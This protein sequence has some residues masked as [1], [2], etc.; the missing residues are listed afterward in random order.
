MRRGYSA[1]DRFQRQRLRILSLF[2]KRYDDRSAVS[3][4]S[5]REPLAHGLSQPAGVNRQPGFEQPLAIRQGIVK[6][7]HAGKIAHAET[8]KPL[9]RHRT[10]LGAYGHLR[11]KLSRV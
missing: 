11:Q 1:L 8:V 9:K 6:F 10:T 7:R 4:S 2:A 5:L 3:F